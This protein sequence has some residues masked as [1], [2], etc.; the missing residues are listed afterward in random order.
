[1]T[2]KHFLVVSVAMALLLS[3]CATRKPTTAPDAGSSMPPP[4]GTTAPA[5][6]GVVPAAPSE[7]APVSSGPSGGLLD[8]RVIY[9]DFDK[10]EVRT[11]DLDLINA[12][13]RYLAS[14]P[15]QKVRVEGHTDARG[16]REY[17]VGLGERRGQ[18]VRRLLM[19]QGAADS[20]LLTVSFGEERPAADGDDETAFAQNRRVELVYAP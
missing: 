17:N 13:A 9:F 14:N 2:A 4:A 1:M 7:A 10:S 8:K 16:T 3:A 20:Q 11:Q 6:T 5:D 18:S 12:H 15:Q 19:V